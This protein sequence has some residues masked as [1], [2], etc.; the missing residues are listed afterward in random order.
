MDLC[1]EVCKEMKL[2]WNLEF[3]L[4]F[5]SEDSCLL[6]QHLQEIYC[7]FSQDLEQ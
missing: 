3:A 5:H 4:E 1:L 6:L 2:E 7:S